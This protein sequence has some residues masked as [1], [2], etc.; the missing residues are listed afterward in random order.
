[1]IISRDFH[2]G[3]EANHGKHV[4]ITCVRS[5]I[6]KKHLPNTGQE[7]CRNTKLLDATPHLVL[8]VKHIVFLR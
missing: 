3:T 5:E 2:G 6:Q 1:M 7:D 4:R 8:L